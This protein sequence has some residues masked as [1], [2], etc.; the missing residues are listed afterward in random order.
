VWLLVA[1]GIIL[2]LLGLVWWLLK[3]VGRYSE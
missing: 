2:A 1:A 3:N